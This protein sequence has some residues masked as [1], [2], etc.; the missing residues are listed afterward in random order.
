[1]RW[2]RQKSEMDPE[3]EK[4]IQLQR[5][6][7]ELR[8]VE[9]ELAE[10]PR[11]KAD[12]D[13]TLAKERAHLETAQ[14]S[15]D[16]CQ[17]SRRHREGELQDLESRRSRYKEQLMTVKTN[18]EYTAMLHEIE[19]V[20]REIREREDQILEEMEQA[21]VL[22]AELKVAG[23]RLK[24]NE[25]RHRIEATTLEQRSATL[26]EAVRRVSAERD[27]IAA[28]ISEE[29]VEL[30]RRV[31]KFRGDAVTR[32]LDGACGACHVTLR[33]QMFLDVRHNDEVRQCP[34]C[35]RILFY[36][37]PAPVVPAPEP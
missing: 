21:E 32:A 1:M 27:A 11:R 24:E 36:E 19:T 12:L 3:L 6:A 10:V 8:K 9:A 23:G 30:F 35:S 20:E 26:G 14:E 34:S 28:T 25:E 29:N 22:A 33:P 4:L 18:R 17:K 37:P 31:T 5:A 16:S 7:T 13:A 2:T 15:L